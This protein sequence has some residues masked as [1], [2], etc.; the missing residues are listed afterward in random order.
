MRRSLRA[1]SVA[2]LLSVAAL[3]ACS[4]DAT[5]MMAPPGQSPS[6]LEP[7]MKMVSFSELV[8]DLDELETLQSAG[9]LD[10]GSSLG[11]IV[12]DTRPV[13]E[14]IHVEMVW[15]VDQIGGPI[16]ISFIGIINTANGRLVLHGQTQ[17]GV[18]AHVVGTAEFTIL[19]DTR[20][21][22]SLVPWPMSRQGTFAAWNTAIA[23]SALMS[24]A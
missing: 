14:T 7:A 24:R 21:S 17:D 23:R 4:S 3:L 13:G 8:F 18:G 22:G 12:I 2:V 6:Q 5:D 9:R 19:T 10:D 16:I 11:I 20:I 15:E 1:V